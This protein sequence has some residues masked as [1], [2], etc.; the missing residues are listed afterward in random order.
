MNIYRA[1]QPLTPLLAGAS[2]C[3]AA[4]SQI[5]FGRDVQPILS[6]RCYNCHGPDPESRKAKLRLDQRESAVAERDGEA[7][8]VPGDTK[9][10]LLV[11]RIL[12]DDADDLMP[13]AKFNK[14][15][16]AEQKQILVKWVEQGAEYDTHWSFAPITKPD[17]PEAICTC[18]LMRRASV[19]SKATV[20]ICAT[21]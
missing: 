2:L 6:D 16:S 11:D 18:T 21:I 3:L 19:P 17:P 7:A 14:P 13:P 8:I 15:L 20:E 10:S 5:D 12:T 1:L 9:A 4:E